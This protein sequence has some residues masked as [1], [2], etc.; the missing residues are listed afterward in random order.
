[1]DILG[2]LVNVLDWIETYFIN[3]FLAFG[4]QFLLPLL[5]LFL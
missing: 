4:F 1:M 5:S 3:G 2:I